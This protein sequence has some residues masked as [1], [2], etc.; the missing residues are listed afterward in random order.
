MMNIFPPAGISDSTQDPS[1]GVSPELQML[2]RSLARVCN[3]IYNK[4][5][6]ERSSSYR[7]RDSRKISQMDTPIK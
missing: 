5:N 4:L 6:N 7:Y 1:L 3:D 2:L